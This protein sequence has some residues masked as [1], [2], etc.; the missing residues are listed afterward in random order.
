MH[1]LLLLTLTI[2]QPPV[3][4]PPTVPSP[5]PSVP[6]KV[7]PVALPT[8]EAA[9]YEAVKQKKPLVF[10]VSV[11]L[12]T[13]PG[14]ITCRVLELNN[15]SSPRILVCTGVTGETT[16]VS[17]ELK[18]ASTDAD[19]AKAAGI[20][21]AKKFP[22]FMEVRPAIASGQG[23]PLI[24]FA[25]REPIDIPGAT[26]ATLTGIFR[27]DGSVRTGILISR[28]GRTQQVLDVNA[29][30]DAIRAAAGLGVSLISVSPF[31]PAAPSLSATAQPIQPSAAPDRPLASPVG[32]ESSGPW[33]A[34]AEQKR[35][36]KLL[37][38]LDVPASDRLKFYKTEPVFQKM[39]TMNN[40]RSKFNDI[41]PS[42]D[43]HPWQVSG[44]MHHVDKTKWRN[45]TG[46]DLPSRIIY[47]QE[48]TDVR[49]FSLVP[50]WRWKF[51]TGTMAY[52]VLIRCQDGEDKNI[53]EVRVHEKR[54]TDW[55][56][57]T[58]YR[59]KVSVDAGERGEYTWEFS[60][61]GIAA[62]SVA[63]TV[64]SISPKVPFTP[65]RTLAVS[66]DFTPPLYVGAG[67]ACNS[68][69]SKVGQLLNVPGRIYRE[70]QRGD[71]GRFSWHPFDA[72]GKID[73]RWPIAAK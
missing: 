39:Y 48:D 20:K 5:P 28:N 51:P 56:D 72:N 31:P 43:A 8:Y 23:L 19:I 32:E 36:R 68:C 4:G 58:V 15:N 17:E 40:G 24:A 7:A 26:V 18:A 53:F 10:F 22:S 9:W 14:A 62:H 25:G 73:T 54:E 41:T 49:A 21:S 47:W 59:P 33:L 55:D 70:A 63:Y 37:R 61:V 60:D 67:V 6:G 45:V 12:R 27:P 11:P 29:S 46:L 64:A 16:V 38:E 2:A 42:E 44:G 57:G 13:V 30:E 1:T 52:D 69:H 34:A 50:K 71:D 66:N 65:T 3:P 35:L